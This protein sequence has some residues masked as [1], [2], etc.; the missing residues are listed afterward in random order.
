MKKLLSIDPQKLGIE[1]GT[2][3]DTWIS[4]GWENR[5]DVMSELGKVD[6]NVG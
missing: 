1:E 4:L 3:G 6:R 5:I 2:R